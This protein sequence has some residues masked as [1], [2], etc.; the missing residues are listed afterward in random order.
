[1]PSK[2]TDE[3]VENPHRRRSQRSLSSSSPFDHCRALPSPLEEL[4]SSP[5]PLQ[6][7]MSSS[8]LIV[9]TFSQ[10]RSTGVSVELFHFTLEPDDLMRLLRRSGITDEPTRRSQQLH[11]QTIASSFSPRTSTAG[12]HRRWMTMQRWQRAAFGEATLPSNTLLNPVGHRSPQPP[13]ESTR[14]EQPPSRPH[15]S[16][17]LSPP[18]IV[19]ALERPVRHHKVSS[20]LTHCHL[21][22]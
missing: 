11:H 12:C 2:A 13:I 7:P 22:V 10:R 18:P 8:G 3:L 1:M 16:P 15:W 6:T 21:T 19:R 4:P 5:H 20:P 9:A 14:L 17:W